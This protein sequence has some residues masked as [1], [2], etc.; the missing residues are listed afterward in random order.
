MLAGE[1]KRKKKKY[2]FSPFLPTGLW[3]AT[4]KNSKFRCWLAVQRRRRGRG[5]CTFFSAGAADKKEEGGNQ[6]RWFWIK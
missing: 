3:R 4:G 1:K 2:G 5:I 6:N